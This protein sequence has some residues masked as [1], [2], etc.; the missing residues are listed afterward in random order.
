MHY[1]LNLLYLLAL[2]CVSPFVLYR[3]IRYGRYKR[4]L[5]TKLLGITC[6]T[7]KSRPTIWIHAV[8]VGE[9]QLVRPLVQRF[10]TDFPQ[11]RIAI[12]TSTDSGYDIAC[13]LYREHFVFFAPLD[14]SWAVSRA[15]R[16][17]K[18][19][20]LVLAELEVWP[21][22][23][24]QAITSGCPVAIVNGRLS[25]SSFRGYSR[26]ALIVR[27]TLA[28]VAW[29]GVQNETYKQRFLSLGAESSRV[30]ITGSIK[31]DNASSSRSADEILFRRQLIQIDSTDLV[32][33]VGST[34][35]P[36]E[37]LM[38]EAFA[39]LRPEIPN[40]RMIIV[41]RH[42]ERFEEVAKKIESTGIPWDRRSRLNESNQISSDWQVFLGDSIG[43]LRWWWGMADIGFVGGSFGDRGGQNMIEPCAF[44]VA[45]S[46]GPNT[47]NFRDIVRLLRD[48]DA[49]KQFE[50][51]AEI[52]PWVME[53]AHHPELRIEMGKRAAL[54]ATEHR[55]AT[56]RTM[57]ELRKL[58]E[59][60]M[61]KTPPTISD[62]F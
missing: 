55:G 17:L 1:L 38:L 60:E 15:F 53:M 20:L 16:D 59:G 5:A 26:L 58:L 40:L 8:S 11:Y 43:E 39:K 54:V 2:L 50:N 22:W 3:A 62:L 32:W 31:F 30:T 23:I 10:A 27:P 56:E 47:K 35:N 4:G 14:F 51:P 9:V 48:K 46:F 44:G 61:K 41:P 24:R 18:P 45:T 37:Q 52:V 7:D 33:V 12:S 21:N 28:S 36:E 49:C 25:E 34:Q 19:K 29:I 6:L 13:E 42:K 57:T